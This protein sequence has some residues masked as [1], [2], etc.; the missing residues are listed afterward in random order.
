MPN[1]SAKQERVA[2]F[3]RFL[4]PLGLVILL[5]KERRNNALLYSMKELLTTNSIV[6]MYLSL[7]LLAVCLLPERA[8]A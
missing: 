7:P 8:A 2:L 1:E 3:L 6:M 4:T 5:H